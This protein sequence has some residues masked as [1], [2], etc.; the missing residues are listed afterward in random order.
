MEDLNK[1]PTQEILQNMAQ[2]DNQIELLIVKYNKLC[3]VIT[4]RFPQV[5]NDVNFKQKVLK[6]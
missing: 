3:N 4:T 6:R 1:K 5:K 2:L